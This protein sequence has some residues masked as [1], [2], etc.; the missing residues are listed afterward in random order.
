MSNFK[1]LDDLDVNGK[2]VLVRLDLN[3][4]MRDG[5]ITDTTRI[6]RAIPTLIELIEGGAIVIILSHF[7]RPKGQV[8]P[9]MSMEVVC[10]DLSDELQT[11]V[12]F[13]DN[14]IGD[15]V[16]ETIIEANAGDVILL[17]NLRFHAGEEKNDPAFAAQ[18]AALGDIY[19]NDAFSCSH[20]AHASTEGIA[21]LLPSAAGR[22]MQ[23]ELEALESALGD[24]EKP[25]GAIVGGAK[26]STK[27]AVLGN[28]I[29]K[30]DIMVIG[31]GMA[32]TFLYANGIDVGSSL[33]EKDMAEEAR[34][35]CDQAANKG[36]EI[37]LPY[38]AVVAN[39]FKAGAA[40][41]TTPLN[42]ITKEAMILDVGIETINHINERLATCKTLLWNGP[43]GAFEI[44]PFD[45]A[46]NAIAQAAA[47]RTEAGELISVAGGGDTVAA[48]A[49]AG[50]LEKF[51]YVSSAG[52]AFLEWLE[53]RD[54]PGVAALKSS[55]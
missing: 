35:I 36:C 9:E 28:L 48:L 33:C 13:V 40:S 23:G 18:L 46:T 49:N 42:I 29:N 53:G 34:D 19:I 25:V 8:V 30:V 51:S 17:E 7:G 54:L 20:R 11:P 44:K 4:P 32:N 24:P 16:V 45:T 47:K 27:M 5:D 26:V 3:V 12:T 1:T 14:C 21:H 31:G 39:E 22:M 2:K 50:V 15:E 43:M 55:D 38:D 10:Q 6:D 37:I 41:A 52:G